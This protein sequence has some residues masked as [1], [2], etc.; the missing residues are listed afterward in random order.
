MN[1]SNEPSPIR[2]ATNPAMNMPRTNTTTYI[3]YKR[4]ES[5]GSLYHFGRLGQLLRQGAIVAVQRAS[6]YAI[7]RRAG[8]GMVYTHHLKWCPE[9]DVGPTPTPPTAGTKCAS[10]PYVVWPHGI[11]SP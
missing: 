2:S 5:M 8:G 4:S 6:R 1:P 3:T 9:R 7:D 10:A 11:I